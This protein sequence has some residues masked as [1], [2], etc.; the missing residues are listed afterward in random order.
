MVVHSP[1]RTVLLA[2]AALVALAIGAAGCSEIERAE[3]G[4]NSDCLRPVGVGSICL[5]DGYC[6][7]PEVPSNCRLTFPTELWGQ[8]QRGLQPLIIGVLYS[9]A[10]NAALEGVQAALLQS[11]SR[12]VERQYRFAYVA[13]DVGAGPGA[14]DV[15]RAGDFANFLVDTVGAQALIVLTG[16]PEARNVLQAV[17]FKNITVLTPTAA[18]LILESQRRSATAP[19]PRSWFWQT[20]PR[21]SELLDR[22]AA[23]IRRAAVEDGAGPNPS[24]GFLIDGSLYTN[25]IAD[26][27]RAPFPDADEAP[28]QA[29]SCGAVGDCSIPIGNAMNELVELPGSL[30][31]IIV[32]TEDANHVN[33]LIE[34]IETQLDTDPNYLEDSILYLPGSA[35]GIVAFAGRGPDF[36]VWLPRFR[37]IRIASDLDSP[38]YPYF[39]SALELAESA[40]TRS[41]TLYS[42]NAYDA[43]WLAQLGYAAAA[44]GAGGDRAGITGQ[45]VSDGMQRFLDPDGEELVR[46]ANGAVW[47]PLMAAISVNASRRWH[48]RGAS[49]TLR[50]DLSNFV[51]ESFSYA[52]WGVETREA[53]DPRGVTTCA[54]G[55]LG[56]YFC[57]VDTYRC[58]FPEDDDC[59]DLE[60]P[61]EPGDP[62]E[63]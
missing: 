19:P 46:P 63:P 11:Q 58:S 59:G 25:T 37:G 30:D 4:A 53:E 28:I 45:A 22:L 26:A 57:T 1:T 49:G 6:S 34:H 31:Y 12:D 32:L 20:L 50:Y 35:F 48:Y 29:Y 51:L 52:V 56:T 5:E 55:L 27:L 9:N 15:E 39:Q 2:L 17:D 3:C 60:D 24:V 42:A 40:G 13:C 44:I 36:A 41:S 43:A 33:R 38:S 61:E 23:E 54:A 7:V 14:S 62:E 21:D 8:P 10:Y 47:D 16:S 18:S